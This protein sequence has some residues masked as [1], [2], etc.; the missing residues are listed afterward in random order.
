MNMRRAALGRGILVYAILLG[1]TVWLAFPLYWLLI[2]AFKTPL[3][4]TEYATYLPWIDFKPTLDAFD[5]AF[6]K[7]VGL[8]PRPFFANSLLIPTG[9][10]IVA[11]LVGSM[12]GYPPARFPY[13]I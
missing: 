4:M 10:G 13:P 11:L 3:A 7:M 6:V 5:K 12:A 8:D 9:A 2:A 1:W